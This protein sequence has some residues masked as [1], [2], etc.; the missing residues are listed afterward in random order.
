MEATADNTLWREPEFLKLWGA[1]AVSLVGSQVTFLALPAT[2]AQMGALTAAS[3]LPSLLVGLYAG[4]VVDRRRRS[5]ILIAGDLGRAAL[6]ATI[7]LAWG[8][9]RLSI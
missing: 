2:A 7:P 4:T 1:Q 9:D 3:A 6:L 8:V 5:P